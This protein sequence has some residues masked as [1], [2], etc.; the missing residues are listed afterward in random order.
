MQ[1]TSLL[2]SRCCHLATLYRSTKRLAIR[3]GRWRSFWCWRWFEPNCFRSYAV[4]C[5]RLGD[6][7]RV[8]TVVHTRS[9]CHLCQNDVMYLICDPLF[10]N[11]QI[12]GGNTCIVAFS[13]VSFKLLFPQYA[14]VGL[15]C[16]KPVLQKLFFI[17]FFYHDRF[18]FN[19]EQWVASSSSNSSLVA[20]QL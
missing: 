15:G 4:L 16:I 20:K 19:E 1:H 14:S 17:F 5:S 7:T 8:V 12:I 18:L 10:T 2:L 9:E 11:G 3:R 6:I 13:S